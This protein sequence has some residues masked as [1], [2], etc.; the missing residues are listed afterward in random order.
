[1]H[2]RRSTPGVIHF[3]GDPTDAGEELDVRIV[4]QGIRT[5]VNTHEKTYLP[6]LLRAFS[7]ALGIKS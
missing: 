6:P 4:S 3:D 2:I 1:L 5:V 7:N